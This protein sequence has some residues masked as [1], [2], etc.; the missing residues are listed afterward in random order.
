MQTQ[1]FESPAGEF[2]LFL[3]SHSQNFCVLL[4]ET[5]ISLYMK[6]DESSRR[7]IHPV[8][9]LCPHHPSALYKVVALVL[10]LH[11]VL[12][13]LLPAH[14]QSPHL[15]TLRGLFRVLL[16]MILHH[17]RRPVLFPRMRR[18]HRVQFQ[19]LEYC[20]RGLPALPFLLS[21]ILRTPDL[22]QEGMSS[23]LKI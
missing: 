7:V 20:H 10:L 21:K 17:F 15:R 22:L 18:L 4:Q 23:L 8:G 5:E 6:N 12:H 19:F 3:L 14:L 16:L 13:I 1:V 2:D 11:L 9:L